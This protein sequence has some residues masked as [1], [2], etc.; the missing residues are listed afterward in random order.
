MQTRTKK[1]PI[2]SQFEGAIVSRILR[3]PQNRWDELLRF[4]K[5]IGYEDI[6]D[7][8][9][10]KNAFPEYRDDQLPGAVLAGIRNREG[11][12]QQQLAEKVGVLQNHISEMEN[13]KR[14]IGKAMARKF[15]SVLNV[16]YKIFL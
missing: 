6:S 11:L 4:A 10:W 3:G 16:G 7:P 9:P 12:T 5:S 14:P 1:P 8:I 13:G 15:A 2:D